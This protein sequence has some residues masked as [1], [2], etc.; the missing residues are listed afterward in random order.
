MSELLDE[1]RA[2]E[3]LT[4]IAE[5]LKPNGFQKLPTWDSIMGQWCAAGHYR[6]IV[7]VPPKYYQTFDGACMVMMRDE[8]AMT[9]KITPHKH[10]RSANPSVDPLSTAL[11]AAGMAIDQLNTL[12]AYISKCAAAILTVI[13]ECDQ[14]ANLQKELETDRARLDWLFSK[15]GPFYRASGVYVDGEYQDTPCWEGGFHPGYSPLLGVDPR[16]AIDLAM[17]T[18]QSRQEGK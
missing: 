7:Y 15:D 17:S 13:G 12:N 8:Q 11:E 14:L 16:G 3:I 6:G 18:P 1:S 2:V 9:V 10:D 4:W 5:S